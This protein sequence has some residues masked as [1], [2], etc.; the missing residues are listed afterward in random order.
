MKKCSTSLVNREMKIKS[1]GYYYT[2]IGI[3]E[4][5]K[6]DHTKYHQEFGAIRTDTLW[7]GM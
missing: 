2:H 5:E 6:T 7:L 3:V 1:T 4:I